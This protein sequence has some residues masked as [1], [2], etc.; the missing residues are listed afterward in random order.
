[1]RR[2][3]GCLQ[4]PGNARGCA[5]ALPTDLA[6]PVV[7]PSGTGTLESVLQVVHRLGNLL[8][9]SW[10]VVLDTLEQAAGLLGRKAIARPRWSPQSPEME[11]SEVERHCAEVLLAAVREMGFS[12]CFDEFSRRDRLLCTCDL[13]ARVGS[14]SH[15]QRLRRVLGTI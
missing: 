3:A 11:L 10:H 8:R 4:D 12:S 9:G 5:L 15:R 6:V 7:C 1:M 2:K 14:G 13:C